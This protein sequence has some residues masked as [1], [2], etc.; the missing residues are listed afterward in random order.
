MLVVHP[1]C[2]QWQSIYSNDTLPATYIQNVQQLCMYEVALAGYRLA[3][4]LDS[5]FANNEITD[6][7][8]ASSSRLRGAKLAGKVRL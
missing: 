8:S 6:V 7:I 2:P 3:Y 1:L 5:V 4:V